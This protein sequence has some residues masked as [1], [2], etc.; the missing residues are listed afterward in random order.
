MIKLLIVEDE[1]LERVALRKIIGREF[2]NIEILEDA[3]NGTEAIEMAK[4]QQPNV[5]LMDIRMPES[6][7]IEAQK[8][9]IQFLPNVKCIIITAYNDF[10]Y[11]QE[12]IKYGVI[13]Y[14]LKPAKPQEIK[15]A[16]EKALSLNSKLDRNHT[17]NIFENNSTQQILM[18]VISYIKQNYKHE[19]RLTEVATM[20]H[21]NPQY[22]SR[23]FKKELGTT[24]TDYVTKLRIEKAKTLLKESNLPIYRIAVDL[25]FS[26]A[27]YFSKVFLKYEKESPLEFKKRHEH[28]EKKRLLSN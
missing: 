5:I 15:N 1:P 7:G 24:F 16:I 8:K 25:G 6:T 22:F 28:F 13:D 10:I 2:H 19:L 9:I 27:A 20:V 18:E 23:L 4:T 14:L 3:K 26:D 21:L 11:A 12:A 17:T